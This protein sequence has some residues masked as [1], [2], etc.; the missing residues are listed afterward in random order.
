MKK[1][2]DNIL[3]TFFKMFMNYARKIGL[4]KFRKHKFNL[5]SKDEIHATKY[6]K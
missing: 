4:I 3:R 6:I 1:I 5:F 2:F